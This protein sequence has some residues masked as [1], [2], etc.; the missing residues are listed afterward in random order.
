M[1]KVENFEFF[2]QNNVT[3]WVLPYSYWVFAK[4]CSDSNIWMK[5]GRVVHYVMGSS[6]D[7]KNFD[8]AQFASDWRV[9]E[10]TLFDFCH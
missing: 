2:F 7:M 6:T 1:M 10:G 3:N 9:C 5:F 4:A 8:F